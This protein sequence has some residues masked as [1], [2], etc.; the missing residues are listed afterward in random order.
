[1]L[2]LELQAELRRR[3][4]EIPFRGI[5]DSDAAAWTQDLQWLQ[6]TLAGT[7]TTP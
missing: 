1:M 4:L 7:A 5:R 3:G 2:M 6:Q